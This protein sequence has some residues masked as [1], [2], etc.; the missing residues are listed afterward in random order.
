MRRISAVAMAISLGLLAVDTHGQTAAPVGRSARGSIVGGVIDQQGGRLPGATVTAKADADPIQ[1]DHST[2]TTESGLYDLTGL[3]QGTYQ[4]TVT[5]PG[6]KTSVR[7]VDVGALETTLNV[8]LDLADVRETVLVR[9]EGS[10]GAAAVAPSV[11]ADPRGPSDYLQLAQRHYEGGDLAGAASFAAR[12]LELIQNQTPAVPIEIS[13]D[14]NAPVRV[15][16]DVR[17]P[18]KVHDI[19][20]VYPV[21]A[22]PTNLHGAVTIEAV[23]SRDGRVTAA[24]VVDGIPGLNESALRAVQQWSYRAASLNGMS[25]P[26]ELTVTVSFVGGS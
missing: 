7:R 21:G 17:A 16:G 9:R 10:A 4:V 8:R 18:T 14:P 3:D 22:D 1:A 24:R 5:R 23:I 2:V 25:V 6:F 13:R 19:A 12:A 20:P 11:Q 26:V 15:G